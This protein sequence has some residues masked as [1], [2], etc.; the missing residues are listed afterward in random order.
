LKLI[1]WV[2]GAVAFAALCGVAEIE[3]PASIVL[4]MLWGSISAIALLVWGNS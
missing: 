4:G 2:A 1:I 3:P